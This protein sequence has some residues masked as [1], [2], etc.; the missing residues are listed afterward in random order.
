MEVRTPS[1]QPTGVS[2]PYSGILRSSPR[3]GGPSV[4]QNSPSRGGNPMGRGFRAPMR[5]PYSTNGFGGSAV[6]SAL[7]TSRLSTTQLGQ[8]PRM[9]FAAPPMPT[10]GVAGHWEWVSDD[11]DRPPPPRRKFAP[12]LEVVEPQKPALPPPPV[13]LQSP[14]GGSMATL[15]SS[16]TSP[17]KHATIPRAVSSMSPTASP[18]VSK[19]LSRSLEQVE[20]E[21]ELEED[22]YRMPRYSNSMQGGPSQSSRPDASAHCAKVRTV[23]KALEQAPVATREEVSDKQSM[24]KAHFQELFPNLSPEQSDAM[25]EMIL[26]EPDE[27]PDEEVKAE[28]LKRLYEAAEEDAQ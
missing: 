22:R 23:P 11:V 20:R 8:S 17:T 28:M 4:A 18:T 21:R 6:P 13:Y 27:E 10:S 19:P 26:N 2:S 12:P 5:S 16:P 7:S 25:F 14:P 3:L 15:A 1:S 24:L 9:Q